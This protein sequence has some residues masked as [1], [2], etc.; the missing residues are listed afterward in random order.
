MK[1]STVVSLSLSAVLVLAGILRAGITPLTT[2]QVASGLNRPLYATAP[3][4]DLER[5]FFIEKRG[6]IRILNLSSGMINTTAFLNID[7]LVGGGTTDES[8]QGLLGLAFHPDYANNGY[9]FV[10]Y[11]NN[12]GSTVV[13]RYTVMD[14][15]PDVA[16]P[17][18][19]LQIISY[20]QP[21]ANHNGGWVGFGPNDGYLYIAS[22][23]GGGAGDTGSGHTAGLGN[24]QD[25][26]SNLLG[27]M[28]RLDINGDDFPADA[29]RNYAVPPG[30]PFVGVTGDDEIWAYG[31]RNPWRPSFDSLTGDLWIADVGQ[32]SWEE[33]DYQPASSAGG[34]NYG[35]RCREGAHNYDTS[36]DCSQT[37]FT[38]PIHE[39]S[40]GGSPFRCSISGG[41]VYRG[42]AIPT[43]QGT[44]F[45]AD[46]CSGQIWSFRYDGATIT[47]FQERTSELDPPGAQ[48]IGDVSSFGVDGYG[49]LYVIKHAGTTTGEIYKIVPAG[50]TPDCNTNGVADA[51]DIASGTSQDANT[52]GTPD[53]CEIAAFSGVVSCAYHCPTPGCT[54]NDLCLTLSQAGGQ[55]V[56]PRQFDSGT[57][58]LR[59]QIDLQQIPTMTVTADA[60]CTDGSNHT[61]SVAGGPGA[62][63]IT[64]TFSP[65]LPDT[66]CC[67]VTLGGGGTGNFVVNMLYGDM[68]LNGAVNAGD[69]NLVTAEL[70]TYANTSPVFWYDVDRNNAINAADR[71]LVR[72]EIGKDL[73]PACP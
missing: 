18:S 29:T 10:N 41:Y 63:Q 65:P 12:S 20:T 27:K 61:A 52:N 62:A 57:G 64:A 31:L 50:G 6:V 26:T 32:G 15:F 47:E 48:T 30:N 19:A 71:N 9:F 43:L 5:L 36:G 11:T 53:E 60:A 58:A 56:E 54:E 68:D 66:E 22:G 40:H 72:A 28:L 42:C 8:E 59:L 16:N 4:G 39:Y 46:Y 24:G 33:V 44:Y 21:Q 13:A 2:I 37:P 3:A 45:F 23:D 55:P 17:G 51:C 25:I 73:D 38:E 69:K 1:R 34:E 35:W 70:G 67:T 49:E 7:S 14:G